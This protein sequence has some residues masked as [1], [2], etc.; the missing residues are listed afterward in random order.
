M[1]GKLIFSTAIDTSGFKKGV[2]LMK[3]TGTEAL[4]AVTTA[5]VATG[6]AMGAMGA[7]ATKASIEFESAFAGVRKTVEAT[8]EE[9]KQLEKGIRDMSKVMPQSASEIAGVAEV[10]GQLGIETAN[11]LSFTK[12]MV[13]LGDATNMSSD[14]AATALARLANITGMSQL[15]FD[16]LGSSIVELGNNLATT[17]KEI[18]D[19]S[20]RLAGTASQVG[21]TEDQILALAGAMSSVG[22]QAQAGG[23]SMSRVMQ[24]INTE[25]LSLGD[26]LD[27]FAKISGMTSDDF[28]KQWSKDPAKAISSFVKGLDKINKSGGDVTSTLKSL[29]ISSTQEIDTLL[30]LSGASD[31]LVDS[32][33]MSNKAWKDNTALVDE[34]NQRYETTESKIAMLRNRFKDLAI[35]IGDELKNALVSSMD[36]IEGYTEQLSDALSKGGLAGAI[37]VLGGIFA[38]M[39]TRIANAAPKA[40][41]AVIDMIDSLINGIESNKSEISKSLTQL[42]T[43]FIEAMLKIIP[44][45]VSIGADIITALIT[46]ITNESANLVNSAAKAVGIILDSILKNAPKIISSGATIVE[47]LIKGLVKLLPKLSSVALSIMSELVSALMTLAPQIIIVGVMLI[48]ELI[49]VAVKMAPQLISLGAVIV[50]SII[51]GISSILPMLADAIVTIIPIIVSTVMGLLPRLVNLGVD[52]IITLVN[53]IVRLAPMLIEAGKK[54]ILTLLD[55]IVRVM[56]TLMSAVALIIP[57]I[58][59]AIISMAPQLAR[60]VIQIAMMILQTIARVLPDIV[61]GVLSVLTAILGELAANAPAIVALVLDTML[62][63]VNAI[64]QALPQILKSVVT[65]LGE[66]IKAIAE[67]APQIVEVVVGV[68]MLLLNSLS[69]LLP[70][71]LE[72]GLQIITAL[73]NGVAQNAHQIIDIVTSTILELLSTIAEYL[74]NILEMGIV[75][76][77]ALVEGIAEAFPELLDIVLDA[78]VQL[79]DVIID[80]ADLIIDAGVLIV[81]ALIE[82][83]VQQIPTLVKEVPRILMAFSEAMAKSEHYIALA[84]ADGMWE[85]I[86]AII[87]ALPEIFN[88]GVEVIDYLTGGL[89]KGALGLPAEIGKII[90]SIVDTFKNFDFFGMAKNI[91]GNIINGMING[92]KGMLGSTKKAVGDVGKSIFDTIKSF[93]KIKSPSRLMEDEIG[94]N[95]TLGIGVGI[96]DNVP[97]VLKGIRSK[98]PQITETMKSAVEVNQGKLRNPMSTPGSTK[99]S[100]MGTSEEFAL[101]GNVNTVINIDGREV[102]RTVTP[103]VSEEIELRNKR[104]R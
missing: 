30:R 55:G 37:K 102:G 34:A 70:L 68:V 9:F 54:I 28:I 8:E 76:I 42:I 32:L 86:K 19:M 82:G 100:V 58:V 99:Q 69:E 6:A 21:M 89:L 5:T 50:E 52:I 17:E 35:S 97:D 47:N 57:Q 101:A 24:K 61:K 63:I 75:I 72:A 43:T 64:Y 26:N 60:M 27:G 85:I 29:G 66:V 104:R 41:N 59:G 93:F 14:E 3:T 13:M 48:T 65:I 67:R 44:K 71:L 10:A 94:K 80:N 98:M 62:E 33:E 36:V 84:A 51:M 25:V 38:D 23:G 88:Q 22:I 81:A 4:K 45:V 90:R 16:K 77:L 56:P 12:S 103:Y 74:P 18:V 7:Y 73:F 2:S 31:V 20:L 1:D 53:T 87:K 39:F 78:I 96:E 46:G 49:N 95:L 83:I 11:I 15:D 91:G 92:M 40:L 79:I